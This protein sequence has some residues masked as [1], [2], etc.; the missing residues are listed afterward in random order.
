MLWCVEILEI[1]EGEWT[2]IEG[3]SSKGKRVKAWYQRV[4][5]GKKFLYKLPK[6]FESQGYITSEIW[7]EIIAYHLGKALGLDIPEA[8]IARTDCDYGVLVENFL[9]TNEV[10]EEAKDFLKHAQQVPSHNICFIKSLLNYFDS[11]LKQQLWQS[12][13]RMLVFDCLIG[14][15]DRH[16]ENWGLCMTHPEGSIRFS[17]FYDNASCL[18][19]ELSDQEIESKWNTDAK[20]LKYVENGKPP[21]LYWNTEDKT[22]Y[23]HFELLEKLI[24][25]E[26]NTTEII[27]DFLKID[28]IDAVNETMKEIRQLEV[29]QAYIFSEHRSQ[30]I[31]NI[32]EL[33]KQR[34]KKL[35]T[36]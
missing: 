19:R 1:T 3:L 20:I 28:Y 10:L 14:N 11:R 16:D 21:N 15:N 5:D 31:L 35:L 29:P 24:Q 13:K 7:T 17:P 8:Q 2:E 6:V 12:Y 32:L 30:I 36:L 23:N 34:M 18:M 22:R 27:E 33:R 9:Q 26:V 25:D 4:S